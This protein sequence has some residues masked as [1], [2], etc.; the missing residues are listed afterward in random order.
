MIVLDKTR[1]DAGGRKSLLVPA[2][3]EESACIAEHPRLDQYHFR[4]PGR[5]ELH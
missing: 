2:L 1:F 3:E 5:L 4:Q